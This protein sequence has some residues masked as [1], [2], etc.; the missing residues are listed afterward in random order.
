MNL[1]TLRAARAARHGTI[2]GKSFLLLAA[3][4]PAIGYAQAGPCADPWIN[5]A[6]QQMYR[7]APVGSGKNVG[8][9]DITRYGNGHWSSYQDLTTKIAQRG[10]GT[11]A[12]PT[13]ASG[14]PLLANSGNGVLGGAPLVKPNGSGIVAQGGGNIVAQGGGNIVAQGGGNLTGRSLQS[15]DKPRASPGKYL[16]I[17]GGSLVDSNGNIV[18]Q[19]GTYMLIAKSGGYG[20]GTGAGARSPVPGTTVVP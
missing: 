20:V 15:V 7:R 11:H 5:Q 17:P 9:C 12:L 10:T 13:V 4:S 18:R 8:E 3:L 1:T 14:N 2:F 6:F 19:A 16:V